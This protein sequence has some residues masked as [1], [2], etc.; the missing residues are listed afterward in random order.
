[1]DERRDSVSRH[2]FTVGERD[3]LL[4]DKPFVVRCGEIHFPRVPREYWRHRLKMCRALGLNAVCVYLF[5]NFHEWQEGVFDWEGQADAAEFCRMAQEEGLWV[6]LRPGPYSCAE[7]EMGGLPWWLI[8][9]RDIGLRSTDPRFIKAARRFL[10]EVGRVLG[11]QQV[12]RGGPILMVQVENEYGS[13][14]KDAAYLGLLKQALVDGGFNVPLFACNPVGDLANGYRSDLFQVVNFGAGMAKD[15]FEALREYQP[16]GPLMNGEYYPA[17]FDMWGRKHHTGA[18]EPIVADLEYMLANRHSFSIYMAHGGTSFGLWAGADRPFSPD[19][20]SYDYDAPI[21]EAG[22]ITPK[23]DAIRAVMA[24]HLQPGESLTDPPLPTPVI[25]IPAF[26]LSETAPVF[27]NL[28]EPHLSREALPMEDIGQSRGA[29]VYRTRLPAGHAERLK[30]GKVHDFAWAFLDGQPIGVMDR[31]TDSFSLEL[32]ARP[33]TARL[34]LLVYAMGRVNFGEQIFDSK[35]LH[36]PVELEGKPLEGWE[37]F[38][39][40]LDP[41][42]LGSLE[43]SPGVASKPAFWRGEFDLE[44]VGDTFLDVQT[45][46]KGVVWINGHTLGRFWNIGPQQTL[47]VPAPWLKEGRNEVIVLDLLGPSDPILS[48][49][50]TPILDEL[51]P[52]LDFSTNQ[53]PTGQFSTTE[54]PVASGE[55]ANEVRWQQVTFN[56]PVSGRYIALEAL[57]S[58]NGNPSAAVAGL[59]AFGANSHVSTLAGGKVFW[60]SSEET[61]ILPGAAVNAVDGQSSTYWHSSA[62]PAPHRLV[63][64]LGE[65][66]ALGG[67]RYLPRAGDTQASGRIRDYHIYVSDQPFGLEL[68]Q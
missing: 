50:T 11:A 44:K 48:G 17:W 16:T 12:T 65:T 52:E 63:I 26:A 30:V 33:T 10:L 32:P 23:F 49:R 15:A 54:P 24:R 22:W 53:A 56:R 38:P 29:T 3:F 4:D 21:S 40:S 1:V 25:Q 64:D 41:W 60:A 43:F 62:V 20:T 59:V 9:N 68:N 45:W 5:W 47:F 66:Y 39:L 36:G 61:D 18:A 51:R 27:D 14:G 6:V 46:G 13:F 58:M 42:E 55:F 2:R 7:W 67:I 8:R 35:G 19:T 37:M 31:R 57:S 28:P 34:D